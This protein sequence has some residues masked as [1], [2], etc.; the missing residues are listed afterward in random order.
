M[1]WI[2]VGLTSL[3]SLK[4]TGALPGT[5]LPEGSPWSGANFSNLTVVVTAGSGGTGAYGIQLAKAW[6]AKHIATATTG[7]AGVA[8]VRSLGA[9][10]I[11]DYAK[12]EL[13]DALPDDSV[14]IVYDNYAAEG[15]ADKA[16]RILRPGGV[17]LM[18]PHGECYEKKTQGPPCLSAT[19][20]SGVRQLNYDTGPDFQQN[21]QAGLDELAALVG[22]R[23]LSTRID[24][25]FGLA[26]AAAAF[27]YSAGPGDGGV[28]SHIGKI[29][30]SMAAMGY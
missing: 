29:A 15:S 20:K 5:P 12:E 4:R 28:G 9:T 24:K 8:F 25:A 19:P 3:F 1:I 2:K 17:Y 14:D 10:Y 11:V 30:L 7:A 21:T 18:L 23:A 27:N 26:D 13:V 6:G 22:Q 16:M